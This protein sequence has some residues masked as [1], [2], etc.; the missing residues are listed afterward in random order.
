MDATDPEVDRI[1]GR[2]LG[3]A[4]PP[5]RVGTRLGSYRL[6]TELGSGGMGTA[7]LAERAERT[8]Q[9][10]VAVKIS[11]GGPWTTKPWS[12][13]WKPSAGF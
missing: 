4:G 7:Y 5:A 2:A 13:A 1:V 9:R 11:Y 12:S 6:L 10:R 8:Y 3:E